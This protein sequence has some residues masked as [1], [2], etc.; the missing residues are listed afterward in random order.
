MRSAVSVGEPRLAAAARFRCPVVL[1]LLLLSHRISPSAA[2]DESL[3]VCHLVD[4]PMY[5]RCDTGTEGERATDVTCFV[6]RPLTAEH[7]VFKALERQTALKSLSFTNFGKEYKLNFVPSKTLRH[8]TLLE[9]LK[10]A[11]AE[12]GALKSHSFYK[13]SNLVDLSIDSNNVTDLEKE[14]IANLPRLKKLDLAGNRLK[15]LPAL[16]LIQLPLLE[17]LLL[18]RNQIET[19]GDL[20]FADLASLAELDLSDNQIEA[21]TEQT[22]K[23]LGR[24]VRLDMFRNKLR[25][26]DARVF[27]GMPRLEDLDLKFN[28]ISEVDPLAF[29]GVSN[30]R[31]IYLSNNRL[32]IL[33]A[34][35]FLGAPDLVTVDLALNEL[36]TLTWRTIE[37]LRSIDE[38][39][40]DMS[41]TGNKF[42]CDCRIA[43]M[44]HLENVT[45]SDKFRREL[46]HV[47]CDF[48]TPGS[49]NSSKVARLTI[50]QLGCAADYD[51]PR[52]H[53]EHLELTTTT[54]PPSLEDHDEVVHTH[55]EDNVIHKA[56]S[57]HPPKSVEDE[58]ME[59]DMHPVKN[60]IDV[61][62]S[63]KKTVQK[64][65]APSPKPSGNSGTIVFRGLVLQFACVAVLLNRALVKSW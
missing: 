38:E 23:G 1:L 35:M 39:S 56:S 42:S 64:G 48:R 8:T 43:W 2:Q 25:R 59:E 3:N 62:V 63:D 57:E 27:S 20:A 17:T 11:Q 6:G 58:D 47:K 15:I 54:E 10:F 21:L 9:K 65:P 44:L 40:F 32:R 31:T 60:D 50:K 13:L 55:D 33:P 36:I 16:A 30:L 29:D 18:E 5:C 45:R 12:L 28:D 4:Q 37:D 49:T 61:L 26:L 41:L 19:I 22:F 46:R 34:N 52:V 24:L 53:K 51:I 7:V 14:S